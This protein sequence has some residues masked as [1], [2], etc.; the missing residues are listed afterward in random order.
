MLH[1]LSNVIE[2]FEFASL[3][4]ASN[5]FSCFA[6]FKTI[7]INIF[8]LL[9]QVNHYFL[10][11]LPTHNNHKLLLTLFSLSFLLLSLD[12][13]QKNIFFLF[14]STLAA[15]HL[16]M[17]PIKQIVS[18]QW[19]T[20]SSSKKKRTKK[21]NSKTEYFE[22]NNN[23]IPSSE[24]LNEAAKRIKIVTLERTSTPN[25]FN[26]CEHCEHDHLKVSFNGKLKIVKIF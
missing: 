9:L 19:P 7:K 16:R 6:N 17:S 15:H 24:E 20:S 11:F 10:Q 25:S 4:F 2:N 26:I 23:I 18:K 12:L 21:M 3:F 22:V 8:F 13:C 14:S 1:F 5:I